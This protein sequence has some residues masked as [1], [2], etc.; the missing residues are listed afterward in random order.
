VPQVQQRVHWD[1]GRA[2]D[3]GL[4]GGYDY[5][6]MRFA[7][8]SH[9]LTNWMGDDGWI[10]TF[11][12]ELRQFN[13]VGDFH[14]VSGSVSGKRMEDGQGIVELTLQATN[15]RGDITTRGSAEVLLPSRANGAV[16]LPTPPRDLLQRGANMMADAAARVRSR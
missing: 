4:P 9:L 7:W 2:Q 10:K 15:Q 13:F 16:V 3:L 6:V 11:G 5:A 14:V 1:D 8:L 12:V